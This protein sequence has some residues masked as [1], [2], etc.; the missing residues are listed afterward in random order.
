MGKKETAAAQLLRNTA[1]WKKTRARVLSLHPLCMDPLGVHAATG[2]I[3]PAS[4]VHH[5]EPLAKRM[6]L[7][8]VLSN[9]APLCTG[10]HAKVEVM[11]ESGVALFPN[12][13]ADEWRV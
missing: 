13:L 12:R 4:Q 9:L 2:R 6:D 11:G 8:L 1:A 7:A 3:E 5:I 10:C